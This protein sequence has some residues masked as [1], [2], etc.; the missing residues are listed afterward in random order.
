MFSDSGNIQAKPTPVLY[1]SG[2]AEPSPLY[3]M[4]ADYCKNGSGAMPVN[5]EAVATF[6]N[7]LGDGIEGGQ[8]NVARQAIYEDTGA[9]AGLRFSAATFDEYT[10][11]Q[12]DYFSGQANMNISFLLKNDTVPLTNSGNIWA[13]GYPAA[14]GGG[15]NMMNF[16]TMISDTA[17]VQLRPKLPG[18]GVPSFTSSSML[19]TGFHLVTAQIRLAP[20]LNSV[21][22]YYDGVF[23]N[24]A[25]SIPAT[26]GNFEVGTAANK[27]L[28]GTQFNGLITECRIYRGNLTP[29]NILT[30][31]NNI[32]SYW[33]L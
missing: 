29:T 32:F 13:Q 25:S 12:N 31:K 30:M 9:A 17:R 10:V 27:S 1:L 11:T 5:G 2:L 14:V 22:W 8:T 21:D 6:L 28:F 26:A 33:G 24:T 15:S 16:S 19:L 18:A 4:R 23:V 3:I 20:T 7:V